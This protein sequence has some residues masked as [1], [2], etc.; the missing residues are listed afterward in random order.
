MYNETKPG[1]HPIVVKIISAKMTFYIYTDE[2]ELSSDI[3]LQI[4]DLLKIPIE[5]MRLHYNNRRLIEDKYTNHDQEINNNT[6]LFAVFK[7]EGEKEKDSIWESISLLIPNAPN[8]RKK[9]LIVNTV[10]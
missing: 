5:N 6:D 10:Q 4:C 3:K 7:K 9:E 2:Y 8:G 1:S